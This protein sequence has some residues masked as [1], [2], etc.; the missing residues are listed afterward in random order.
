MP[1]KSKYYITASDI[2]EYIYCQCCWW[3][4]VEGLKTTNS[5]MNDG[6]NKHIELSN[7]LEIFVRLK[8]IAILLILTSMLI[9]LII[10]FF[11]FT[12]HLL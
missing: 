10:M 4:K 2:A 7:R 9:L 5:L 1:M 11:I 8:K 6:T 12:F 3:D